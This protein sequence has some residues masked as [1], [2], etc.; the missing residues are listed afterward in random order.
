MTEYV[1]KVW[2]H[3]CSIWSSTVWVWSNYKI[4]DAGSRSSYFSFFSRRTNAINSNLNY[5]YCSKQIRNRWC[6]W[7]F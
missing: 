4:S 5:S 2:I 1:S 6:E 3:C 7:L